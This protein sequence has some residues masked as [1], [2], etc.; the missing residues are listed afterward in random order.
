MTKPRVNVCASKFW[1][2]GEMIPIA[3]CPGREFPLIVCIRTDLFCRELQQNCG[4]VEGV[5]I[6]DPSDAQASDTNL[7]QSN[8]TYSQGKLN[9]FTLK[10]T[11]L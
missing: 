7:K 3:N 9:K 10:I 8:Q 4:T 11:L 6:R 2:P 1:L 5:F